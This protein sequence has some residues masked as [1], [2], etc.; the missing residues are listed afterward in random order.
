MNDNYSIVVITDSRGRDLQTYLNKE[1]DTPIYVEILSG[2]SFQDS[3]PVVEDIMSNFCVEAF[4][5][6]MGINNLT[7]YDYVSKTCT[8]VYETPI[9]LAF[10]LINVIK[11]TLAKLGNLFPDLPIVVCSLYGMDI[12]YYHKRGCYS[13][14]EQQ[15]LD[16]AIDLI[17]AEIVS[18]N[19]E[20]SVLTPRISNIVHRFNRTRRVNDTLYHRLY[21]G[22]H[23]SFDTQ[24]HIA[25]VF[26]RTMHSN[27]MADYNTR[28]LYY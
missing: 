20:N 10:H 28:N 4:Y 3:I 1:M 23:P 18:I 16:T 5:I 14:I 15:T 7:V 9:E 13:L 6:A 11:H 8:L 17:N 22:L 12:S 27:I 25:R 19:Q 26:S 24:A 2:K 21:D